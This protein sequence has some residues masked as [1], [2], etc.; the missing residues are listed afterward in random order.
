MARSRKERLLSVG[1]DRIP[2]V[3]TDRERVRITEA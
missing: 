1:T 3:S 2:S